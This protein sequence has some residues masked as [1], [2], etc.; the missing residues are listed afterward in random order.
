MPSV[1]RVVN[2]IT[3]FG[4]VYKAF[5]NI[6]AV[7]DRASDTSQT[8]GGLLHHEL[9]LGECHLLPSD[10]NASISP[11]KIVHINLSQAWSPELFQSHILFCQDGSFWVACSEHWDALMLGW[12]M[13]Q[14]RD[15]SKNDHLLQGWPGMREIQRKD[16]DKRQIC[17]ALKYSKWS[18][19]GA[20]TF[21]ALC[22]PQ[23]DA[24]S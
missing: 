19:S 15:F 23:Q 2:L 20:W 17:T 5:Q 18:A 3:S 1:H 7:H 21:C 10:L 24:S 9:Q 14:M 4:F 6:F 16:R 11:S 8:L 22:L 13:R 12:T